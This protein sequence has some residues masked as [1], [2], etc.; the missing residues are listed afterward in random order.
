MYTNLGP[1]FDRQWMIVDKNGVFLSQR[2][3]PKMC[4]IRATPQA[5]STGPATIHLSAPATTGIVASSSG[6]IID[7]EVWGDRVK[8]LDYGDEVA[9]WLS[10]LLDKECRL[11]GVSDVTC[12][13]VDPDYA[14]QNQT[15]GF[16]DGFPTL[17]VGQASLDEFNIE[18]AKR[19]ES[20]MAQIDEGTQASS[21]P[22][23]MRR[24]RP[25]I[26][27]SGSAPY[28]EDGWTGIK[29]NDIEFSLVKAC[30][31]CIMPS[32][33]PDTGVKEMQVN[34]TLLQTRR[35]DRQTYFGQ[36]ALHEGTGEIRVGDTVELI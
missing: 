18:L 27:I 30:S 12:R 25:N 35:R 31:R 7:V 33:N 10:K 23:D 32:I 17:V 11:V 22:I 29:V 34:Q 15:V 26:V 20:N 9:A 4:L 1:Q 21:P 8:A 28:A 19:A 24:F 6:K 16:A 14:N 2:V 13:L 36:N 5:S 3:L